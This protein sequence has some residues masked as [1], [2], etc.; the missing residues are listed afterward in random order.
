MKT[1][2]LPVSDA[3]AARWPLS[4]RTRNQVRFCRHL[5][6]ECLDE[7]FAANYG[8]RDAGSR[9]SILKSVR[10]APGPDECF[11]LFARDDRTV[12]RKLL[13]LEV[14]YVGLPAAEK[15]K[16]SDYNSM[17][18]YRSHIVEHFCHNGTTPMPPTEGECV[19]WFPTADVLR[20]TYRMVN[21]SEASVPVRLRWFSEGDP[22][23]GYATKAAGARILVRDGQPGDPLRLPGPGGDHRRG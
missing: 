19:M 4:A 21:K 1:K 10:T 2:A 14:K 22:G 12:F 23:R 7:S 18:Y 11:G 15:A 16:A 17:N 5:P 8:F 3:L 9:F 20:L 13:G 6:H